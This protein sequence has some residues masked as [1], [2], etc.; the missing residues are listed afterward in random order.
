MEDLQAVI[1]KH[2]DKLRAMREGLADCLSASSVV[3]AEPLRDL[4]LLRFLIG[5]KLDLDTAME[6]F[7]TMVTY[8]QKFKIDEIRKKMDQGMKPHQFPGYNDVHSAWASTFYLC[9]GATKEGCPIDMEQTPKFKFQQLFDL[10]PSLYDTYIMH[11]LEYHFYILDS[12]TMR[13]GKITGYFKIMDLDGCSLGQLKW[14]RK[15]QNTSKARKERLG[16]D[17]MECYPE[18]FQKVAI[19]NAPSFFSAIWTLVKPFIP[20]RTADKVKVHS[21][22]AKSRELLLEHIDSQVLPKAVGGDFDGEWQMK[23]I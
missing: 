14:V 4:W 13:T 7:R 21:G 17:L 12:I 1:A 19:V 20:A 8:R 9:S 22:N 10:E 11:N 16:F 2:E 23:P 18:C 5:F 3:G 6:K 15:W